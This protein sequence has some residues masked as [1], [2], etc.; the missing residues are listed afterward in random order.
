M[1]K[2]DPPKPPLSYIH[3]LI[4]YDK[5]NCQNAQ[6]HRRQVKNYT[7]KRQQRSEQRKLNAIFH[8]DVSHFV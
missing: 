3:I 2:A 7:K 5:D 8:H 1:G 4:P 6:K